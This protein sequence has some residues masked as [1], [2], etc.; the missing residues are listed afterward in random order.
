MQG[1]HNTEE[2]ANLENAVAELQKNLDSKTQT[3]TL[4]TVQL[5]K[6]QVHPIFLIKSNIKSNHFYQIIV[7]KM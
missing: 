3:H 6:I 1:E 2:K 4:L 7:L 5:K